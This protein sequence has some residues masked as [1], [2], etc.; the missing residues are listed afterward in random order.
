MFTT[1]YI[2]L[3]SN[4]GDRKVNLEQACELLAER[5]GTILGCSKFYETEPWGFESANKFLNAALVIRTTLTPGGLLN[6]TQQMEHEMGRTTKEDGATYHDRLIDIDLLMMDDLIVSNERLELPHPLMHKRKFVLEPLAEIA[7][8]VKHPL[9][10]KTM[11]ELLN[12]LADNKE[13]A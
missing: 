5:A 11:Q 8:G 9:L 2:G 10:G 1:A 6:L 4:L 7:P 13:Q 12:D 3:G